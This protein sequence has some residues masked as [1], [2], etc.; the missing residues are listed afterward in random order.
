[1]STL[2]VQDLDA[3]Q[4]L[5]RQ[6]VMR[7][8]GGRNAL[9]KAAVRQYAMQRMMQNFSQH[10]PLPFAFAQTLALGVAGTQVQYAVVEQTALAVGNNNRIDQNVTIIQNQAG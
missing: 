1:M 3:A 10:F 6:A 7:V 5:D 4:S 8:T 9:F 2:T